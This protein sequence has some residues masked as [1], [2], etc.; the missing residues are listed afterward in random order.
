MLAVC[1][2]ESRNI[3]KE[4]SMELQKLITLQ[5]HYKAQAT[6][7]FN[8]GA[9]DEAASYDDLAAALD[10][11]ILELMVKEQEARVSA[12]LVA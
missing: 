4:I 6:F 5:A 2:N 12:A 3:I 10:A 9:K 11:Q 8:R 1:Y 7:W